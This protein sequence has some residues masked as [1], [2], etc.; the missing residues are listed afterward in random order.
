MNLLHSLK[1]CFFMSHFNIIIPSTLRYSSQFMVKFCG[2]S[3][4]F[5]CTFLPHASTS[6]SSLSDRSLTIVTTNLQMLVTRQ[7]L[8]IRSH[9]SVAH[10]LPGC[11]ERITSIDVSGTWSMQWVI[12][13]LQC[14]DFQYNSTPLCAAVCCVSVM[15]P[16]ATS[17]GG[18]DW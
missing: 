5:M 4:Q 16:A 3:F 17:Q 14:T 9:R 7:S 8:I 18:S 10:I 2:W 11:C 13:Q 1:P 12:F 15:R 6:H